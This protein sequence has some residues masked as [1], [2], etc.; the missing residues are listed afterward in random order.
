MSMPPHEV[1]STKS[2][3][4]VACLMCLAHS[5]TSLARAKSEANGRSTSAMY[6]VPRR[7]SVPWW[8][9]YIRSSS[10]PG[11]DVNSSM[12]LPEPPPTSSLR[13]SGDRSFHWLTRMLGKPTMPSLKSSSR[14]F[15]TN[16]GAVVPQTGLRHCTD[17]C[18]MCSAWAAST[19]ALAASSEIWMRPRDG[20]SEN[21][22]HVS[23]TPLRTSSS[24][25]SSKVLKFTSRS[26][27]RRVSAAQCSLYCF[28]LSPPFHIAPSTQFA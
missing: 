23:V 9:R 26:A 16:R 20:M 28:S 21:S 1:T 3:K 7:W 27:Q 4:P 13:S 11:P 24:I 6:T 10:A 18:V 5:T 22:A 25:W 14:W 15:M 12:G 19:E 8:M 17:R 2:L